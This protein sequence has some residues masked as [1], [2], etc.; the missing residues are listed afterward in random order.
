MGERKANC[1]LNCVL[2][3]PKSQTFAN[4]FRKVARELAKRS[5][6]GRNL[7]DTDMNLVLNSQTKKNGNKGLT[8]NRQ[9]KLN[10]KTT[11]EHI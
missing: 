7:C 3:L 8:D 5:L 9:G 4:E 10:Q 1:Y 6:C 2:T 11:N